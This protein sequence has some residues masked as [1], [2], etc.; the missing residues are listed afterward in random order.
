MDTFLWKYDLNIRGS[1]LWRRGWYPRWLTGEGEWRTASFCGDLGG[2]VF[3]AALNFCRTERGD[4][5]VRDVQIERNGEA[6]EGSKEE[7]SKMYKAAKDIRRFVS[8][9]E[10]CAYE[11]RTNYFL[12]NFTDESEEELCNFVDWYNASVIKV[13]GGRQGQRLKGHMNGE[14]GEIAPG[15]WFGYEEMFMPY[16]SEDATSALERLEMRGT[17]KTVFTR[18]RDVC[19]YLMSLAFSPPSNNYDDFRHNKF[20]EIRRGAAEALCHKG[21]AGE[22]K[23]RL[24]KTGQD[25]QCAAANRALR[26][27]DSCTDGVIED[28]AKCNKVCSKDLHHWFS[29]HKMVYL[30]MAI[31]QLF[32]FIEA[33][34]RVLDWI[35]MALATWYDYPE[36][37]TTDPSE[38]TPP[39]VTP[40]PE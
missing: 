17:E 8:T 34:R 26:K 13:N 22:I 27:A 3:D 32:F 38:K 11:N 33:V 19:S 30:G 37:P 31:L 4:P 40:P 20:L 10:D 5:P 39:E 16:Y 29:L 23:D 15:Y 25:V 1:D 7:N 21:K 12:G 35:A 2:D 36:S 6:D 28:L 9:D 18:V 24:C 14:N